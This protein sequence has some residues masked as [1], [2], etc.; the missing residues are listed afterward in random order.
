MKNFLSAYGLISRYNVEHRIFYDRFQTLKYGTTRNRLSAGVA[1]V[2]GILLLI[3]GYK[4]ILT[5]YSLVQQE[6]MIYTS[7]QFWMFILVPVGILS[8]L[9]QLGGVTVLMG[10][11][12]FAA[13]RVNI[14]KFLL[15]VGTGQGLFTIAFH[16]ASEISSGRLL[17]VGNNYIVWITTS[18]VA[19]LEILFA[20]ISQS[21]SKGKGDSFVSRAKICIKKE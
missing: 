21:I 5:V 2:S 10:A 19:G 11:A 8:I 3:S 7:T 9:S 15:S 13:K 1:F 6:I 18:S 14:E 20:V 16:V 12:L 4:A 17:A